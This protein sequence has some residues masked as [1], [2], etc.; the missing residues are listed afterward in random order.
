MPRFL[1]LKTRNNRVPATSL[2]AW[3]LHSPSIWDL[4]ETSSLLYVSKLYRRPGRE[5]SEGL[6]LG[7]CLSWDLGSGEGSLSHPFT[8]PAHCLW[9]HMR[10]AE[11]PGQTPSSPFIFTKQLPH[12]WHFIYCFLPV[13]GS[14]QIWWLWGEGPS[15][16]MTLVHIF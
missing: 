12:S 16:M 14:R 8:I 7:L 15:E 4:R 5:E 3:L 1:C 13:I 10:T 11:L 2:S 6:C 9:H